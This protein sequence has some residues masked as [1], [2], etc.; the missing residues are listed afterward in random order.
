MRAVVCD[1]LGDPS[2]LKIEQR[3]IPEPGP[4]DVVIAVV[5]AAVNFP[6]ILTVLGQYQ[7]KPQLPFVPGVTTAQDRAFVLATASIRIRFAPR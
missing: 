5:A 1:R 3:P 4:T 7:H 2:V 6:D